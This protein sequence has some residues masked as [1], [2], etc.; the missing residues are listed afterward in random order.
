MMHVSPRKMAKE[1]LYSSEALAVSRPAT[2]ETKVHDLK[3]VQTQN[4]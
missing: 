4:G 2:K 1:W 3:T